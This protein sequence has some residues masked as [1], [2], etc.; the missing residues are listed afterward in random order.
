[1]RA[2]ASA[3][4][5]AAALPA[6]TSPSTTAV[7]SPAPTVCQ[8]EKVTFADLSMASAASNSATRPFVSIIPSACFIASSLLRCDLLEQLNIFGQVQTTG[9][10]LVG[11][12]MDVE[13]RRRID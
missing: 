11:V 6:A 3:P 5:P 8:P 9:V 2:A 10:G 1:M 13:A 7:T 12:H 4:A